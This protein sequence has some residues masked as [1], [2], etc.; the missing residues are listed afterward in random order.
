[1]NE[2][3]FVAVIGA[4]GTGQTTLLKTLSGLMQAQSGQVQ[5]VEKVL[6]GLNAENRIGQWH[7][8]CA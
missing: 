6:N 5:L 1:M 4:N 2:G 3:E 7:G 8:A